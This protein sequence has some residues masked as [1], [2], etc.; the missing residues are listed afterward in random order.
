MDIGPKDDEHAND[1]RDAELTGLEHDKRM[2]VAFKPLEYLGQK[3][4]L[5]PVEG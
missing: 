2:N 4:A 5:G 1:G 3:P